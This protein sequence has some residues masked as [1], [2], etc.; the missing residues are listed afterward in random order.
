MTPEQEQEINHLK[1]EIK[2]IKKALAGTIKIIK[3]IKT[4]RNT[5]A[6]NTNTDFDI[7]FDSLLD[8]IETTETETEV[9]ESDTETEETP[10][11]KTPIEETPIEETPIEPEV[12][13]DGMVKKLQEE[14]K[15][16]KKELKKAKATQAVQQSVQETQNVQMP[17]NMDEEIV[18]RTRSFLKEYA[19]ILTQKKALQEQEREIKAEYKDEGVNVQAAIKAWKEYQKEIKETSEEAHETEYIKEGIIKQDDDIQ[20]SIHTLTD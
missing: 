20:T 11:E 5:M 13:L 19:E 9:T 8:D 15:Q 6:E 17:E 16:L 2:S 14:I 10:I 12:T 1:Q 18:E 4:K 7:D 3:T